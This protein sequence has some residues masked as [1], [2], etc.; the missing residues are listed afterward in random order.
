MGRKARNIVLG[1]LLL[2]LPLAIVTFDWWRP[3]TASRILQEAQLAPLPSDAT[4]VEIRGG[5]QGFG[6]YY[7]LRFRASPAEINRWLQQ[8]QAA[9]QAGGEGPI[10][11]SR[12]ERTRDDE[13]SITYSASL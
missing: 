13:L 11:T 2:G 12:I 5:K 6:T 7:H 1:V 4:V 8:N 3:V 9:S 10:G